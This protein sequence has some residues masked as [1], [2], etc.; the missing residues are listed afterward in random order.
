M[1][2]TTEK[3]RVGI[4]G[5]GRAGYGMHCSEI[6]QYPD[7]IEIVA[8]CDLEQERLE[9]LNKRYPQAQTYLDGDAF[10]ADPDVEVVAV[11]VRSP[12]HVD[13]A[14]RALDAG[15]C[16]FLEK[17]VAL[18]YAAARKLEAA[19]RKRPEKL[20]F[21]HNRRFEAAFHHVLEIMHSG[22]LGEVFEIK[23]AR[24]EFSFRADWQ[25]IVDCGGGQLNNWGPHLIDQSLRLLESPLESLWS[26]LK[27]VTALGD[28]EDHV[29]VVMRGENGR[30]V[31][32]E[33]SDGVA[34][35]S[36]VYAVYGTRGT[37]ISEDEQDIRLKY[38]DPACEMPRGRRSADPG[39]PPIGGSFHS[40]A[41]PVR[42]V[43]KTIMVEPADKRQVTDIYHDLYLAIR[44]HVPFPVTLEEA[45]GNVKVME[46]IKKQ[47]PRFR[48]KADVFGCK[49]F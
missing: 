12:Q 35:P 42:W 25:A 17:P 27:T 43:R 8:G 37:L 6:D 40:D 14:L 33:I 22:V 23:L 29:K 10:L 47:N 48:Q 1:E 32:F 49:T 3:L 26:D 31:D 13:Y 5:L 28:A 21:R 38:V 16:V 24:H 41:E 9:L 18:T 20:F 19:A 46:E 30:V 15:K 2:K 36:P 11:A 7:E 34:I 4:W 39:T 44:K 45:I